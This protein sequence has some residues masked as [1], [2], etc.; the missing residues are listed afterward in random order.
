MDLK[1]IF[2]ARVIGLIVLILVVLFIGAAFNANLEGME[3]E[4]PAVPRGHEKK[5][6]MVDGPMGN[7]KKPTMPTM[8]TMPTN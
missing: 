3:V 5:E 1:K 8:P 2:S 7:D 6:Q 4:E